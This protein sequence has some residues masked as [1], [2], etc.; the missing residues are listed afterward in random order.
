MSGQG[1][2][3]EALHSLV[4][5]LECGWSTAGAVKVARAALSTAEVAHESDHDALRRILT[6]V[7]SF[8][9]GTR[10][11]LICSR[12]PDGTRLSF[13]C[14][15]GG[16]LNMVVI[17]HGESTPELR[18]VRQQIVNANGAGEYEAA[19]LEAEGVEVERVHPTV[20]TEWP[21]FSTLQHRETGRRGRLEYNRPGEC[22]VRWFE[23]GTATPGNG[24]WFPVGELRRYEPKGDEC[25]HG[26]EAGH[27]TAC[28]WEARSG[29]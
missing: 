19:R 2:I 11:G 7:V 24:G 9:E 4:R 28:A 5:H 26:E 27:C 10:N 15:E 29:G 17:Q 14:G 16:R 25:K 22:Y 8:E 23:R 1:A 12:F 18:Q 20:N 3:R 6:G 13:G 21:R